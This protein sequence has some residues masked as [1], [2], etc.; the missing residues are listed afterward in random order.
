MNKEQQIRNFI[1]NIFETDGGFSLLKLDDL[2]E[3]AEKQFK[4]RGCLPLPDDDADI[5]EEVM[6][7]ASEELIDNE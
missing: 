6:N 5:W 4:K 7:E 3:F 2:V 1:N